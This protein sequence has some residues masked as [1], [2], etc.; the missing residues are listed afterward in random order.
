MHKKGTGIR[1]VC[2]SQTGERNQEF[3]AK[4]RAAKALLHIPGREQSTPS[5]WSRA[6]LPA[7]AWPSASPTGSAE[8]IRLDG[9]PSWHVP[10]RPGAPG[11]SKG[12]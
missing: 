10:R 12:K 2:P 3:A 5:K 1:A 6:P 11:A 4:A 8:T 9:L 7:P